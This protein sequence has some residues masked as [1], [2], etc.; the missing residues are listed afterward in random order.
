[1][2]FF[3]R[4]TKNTQ[5]S[6]LTKIRP[7]G[8]ELLREDWQADDASSGF[9]NFA[10]TT[11]NDSSAFIIPLVA[12]LTLLSMHFRE[13]LKKVLMTRK[14]DAFL[15]MNKN[16]AS[17]VETPSANCNSD[18]LCGLGNPA[19]RMDRLRSKNAYVLHPFSRGMEWFSHMVCINRS[20]YIP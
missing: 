14:E 5:I 18:K 20:S 11:D 17:L 6:H 2:D 7:A 16:C 1:L 13:V 4:F 8:A 10:N 19:L 3:D 15:L 9:R 12:V